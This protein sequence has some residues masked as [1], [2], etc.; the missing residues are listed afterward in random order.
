MVGLL[1]A[2]ASAAQLK[3]EYSV[4]DTLPFSGYVC[5]GT[6]T[7]T[8][9][10][11][12]VDGVDGNHISGE[13]N[14]DI[15]HVSFRKTGVTVLPRNLN[16]YFQNFFAVMISDITNYP[17]F[18]RSDF[19]DF[20][21]LRTFY[22]RNLPLVTRIP[23]DTFWD[24]NKL[25]YLYLDGMTN[26]ENLDVDLLKNLPLL[27]GFSAAGPNK[28]NQI[29]PGF[30]RNQMDSLKGVTFSDTNLVQV[31]YSVF[32]NLQPFF[33]ADFRNSGCVNGRYTK[34]ML[35]TAI[36]QKCKDVLIQD[37]AIYPRFTNQAP[38]SSE[39]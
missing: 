6:I 9:T 39:Q 14:G 10:D 4:N 37:N 33:G 12:F 26:M 35:T 1:A 30:F 16:V 28:I 5:E 27:E 32:V 31:G 29:S 19:Y 34:E 21:R 7:S 3:C 18:K 23:R 22:A 11:Y 15:T 24:L 38:E 36:R 20:T 17:N 25:K 13:G 2:T 8:K